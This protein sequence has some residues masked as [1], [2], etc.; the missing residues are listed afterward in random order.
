MDFCRDSPLRA[1]VL[2]ENTMAESRAHR[3]LKRWTSLWLREQ[4]YLAV[5]IEVADPTGRFRV[6]VAGWTDRDAQGSAL[7]QLGPR[8][9]L[10]ECKQSRGDFFRDGDCS[11]GLLAR[12]DQLLR[13]LERHDME[14][15]GLFSPLGDVDETLFK[16]VERT[17]R[18]SDRDL[19]RV[20]VELTAIERRLYRGMK[21]AKLRRWRGA[22][23]LL[24][25]APVGLIA[26]TELPIG[27]GLLE[28]PW[29]VL[30]GQVPDGIPATEVVTLKTMP[31][32][33]QV[34]E[35][36]EKRLL[37]NIAVANSR[38]VGGRGAVL[39]T[40]RDLSKKISTFAQ[41]GTG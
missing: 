23:R 29:S 1:E 9:V 18:R 12:R 37:R 30:N 10:V 3:Q 28:V 35:A 13:E 31:A 24:I 38:F 25:A 41:A 11:S 36:V 34:S 33:H 17:A 39:G 40:R 20:R 5:G 15:T 4:G 6:D 26:C 8:T 27:W 2:M 22:S 32:V 19:R 14:P 7:R 16:D 21:F